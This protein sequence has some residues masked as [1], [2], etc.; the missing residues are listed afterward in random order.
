MSF[1]SLHSPEIS[2]LLARLYADAQQSHRRPGPGGPAG[3]VPRD[4]R[5]MFHAMRH[6]YMCIAPDFGQLLYALV[7]GSGARHVVEFGTSMGVSAIYLAAAVKDNGGGR[8]ITTEYEPEKVE[9]ARQNIAD[10]GL[11]D[12]VEIRAGDALESLRTGLPER[13][14]LVFL[15][16]AKQLY[17][18]VLRL[19][20]PKLRPGAL[21]A[22]DNTDH[23][24]VESFLAYLRDPRNGYVSSGILTA[25]DGKPSG[26]EISVRC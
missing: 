6:A 2:T 24:G 8:V 23:D 3:G 13:I 17:L 15:D 5:E 7:R 4:S 11:A 18:D 9:R 21:I 14:D 25:R 1:N 19:I 22:S 12:V 16:G 10:A 26:H 20:E